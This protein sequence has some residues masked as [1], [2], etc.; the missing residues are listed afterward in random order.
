MARV[1][2]STTAAAMT[3]GSPLVI[4]ACRIPPHDW[5]AW[6]APHGWRRMA[7][8]VRRAGVASRV[9]RP[10][11]PLRVARSA[12][13][14]IAA[15][16]ALAGCLP[17]GPASAAR[18]ADELRV[19]VYNV[20]AGKDAAGVDNLE[21]VSRLLRARDVDVAL[22]QE[23]DSLTSRSGG[24]DQTALLARL[25]GL[26]GVFGRTLDYQGGGYGV[27]IL[28]R[29]PIL[30]DT[31]VHLPVDPPQERAGGSREPRGALLATVG[32]RAGPLH[33]LDTH[34]DASREDHFRLQEARHVAALLDSLR[35]SGAPV[36]GG[37]DLNAPAESAVIALLVESGWRDGWIACG[38]A[39][40]G[41]TFPAAAPV[42]RID[43]L[44]LSPAI[45]CL[46]AE[47]VGDEISDHRG[48][49]FT[50]AP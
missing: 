36:L 25:T 31:V 18:P 11:P 6:L 8:Q 44:F 24:V 27:A 42:K 5:R 22:L 29:D 10:R 12:A 23:V 33:V 21:R 7:G 40:A 19:L 35:R 17:P 15:L 26:H 34:L 30:V 49:L 20:H 37:G 41:L 13:G 43:F 39:G 45:R 32:T 9:P 3:I 46:S 14:A 38:G 47:V 2:C 16:G 28:S 50:L 1:T 4:A 48:V